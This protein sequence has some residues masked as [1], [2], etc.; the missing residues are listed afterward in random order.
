MN[1]VVAA[2]SLVGVTGCALVSLGHPLAASAV[3]VPGN[4]VMTTHLYKQKEWEM[5]WMFLIYTVIAVY[6]VLNLT[7]AI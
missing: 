7:G 2:A 5:F 6:G 4:I 1:I 3:W